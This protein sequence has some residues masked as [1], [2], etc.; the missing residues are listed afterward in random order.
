METMPS[1]GRSPASFAANAS[2]TMMIGAS[3]TY[4]IR[5]QATTLDDFDIFDPIEANGAVNGTEVVISNLRK[6]W[7]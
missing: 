4:S 5:G 2:A 1:N 7:S 3:V 6:N